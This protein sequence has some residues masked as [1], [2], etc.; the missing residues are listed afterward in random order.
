MPNAV[1]NMKDPAQGLCVVGATEYTMTPPGSAGDLM[2]PNWLLEVFTG[3]RI[4][5]G[6]VGGGQTVEWRTCA[7]ADGVLYSPGT[8]YRERVGAPCRSVYVQF[9]DDRGV[10]RP[11]LRRR[12][13]L[14]LRDEG[15]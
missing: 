7:A 11:V 1:R 15:R 14:W 5:I 12:R 8:H 9:D 10:M 3:G 2:S 6:I 4:Y 13:F